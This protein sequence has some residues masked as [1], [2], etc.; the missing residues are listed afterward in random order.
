[1]S[2]TALFVIDIQNELANDSKTEIPQAARI[3]DA[4]TEILK[5]AR[6]HINE[7]R[8]KGEDPN[9]HIVVVQHEEDPNS[10]DNPT[11]IKGTEAWKLVFEPQEGDDLERLVEKTT[12]YVLRSKCRVGDL[13][14]SIFSD[15]FES[16]PKLAEQLREEGVSKIV[17][18]GIQSEY[19]VRA[20]SKGALAA[21]FDVTLLKG[22]HS[23]Y[24]TEERSARVIE[25]DVDEELG[26]LGAKLL[27]W[28]QWS[29]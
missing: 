17:A 8:E 27:P 15:T 6:T 26:R 12:G 13:L 20:T 9:L 24:D 2:K 14:K 4:G 18:F 5:R 23:T 19:C 1:M 7:S 21:G 22:A 16:N 10:D 29:P 28:E 3:R 25:N 11:L